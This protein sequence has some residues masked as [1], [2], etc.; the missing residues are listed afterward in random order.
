ME[1]QTEYSSILLKLIT[2]SAN[3]RFNPEISCKLIFKNRSTGRV[4]MTQIGDKTFA[5][6]KGYGGNPPSIVSFF[7][8]IDSY[9]EA[10]LIE[11]V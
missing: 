2:S 10:M 4:T 5:N 8:I 1:N 3:W 9:N 11:P 7:K 6:L